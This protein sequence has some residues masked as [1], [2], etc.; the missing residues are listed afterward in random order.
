MKVKRGDVVYL[1]NTFQMCK[2]VQG[3]SRPYVVVSNNIGNFH[4]EICMV[5]P[6]T[7]S[8]RKHQL[9]THTVVSY[10]NSICLCEQIFT[11]SQDNISEVKCNLSW[12]DMKNVNQCLKIALGCWR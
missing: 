4:S 8:K 12:Y 9:P 3:G 2:H 10:A 5:V 11:V 6:L 7:T 1:K